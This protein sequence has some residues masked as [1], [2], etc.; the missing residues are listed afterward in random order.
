MSIAR[1]S[2]LSAGDP[3]PRPGRASGESGGGGA[4]TLS[5]AGAN[6]GGGQEEDGQIAAGG[7]GIRAEGGGAKLRGPMLFEDRCCSRTATS[8]ARELL[9]R[10]CVKLALRGCVDEHDEERLE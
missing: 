5:E 1:D 10:G 8:R 9:F 2:Y 4:A 7:G 3:G 6:S